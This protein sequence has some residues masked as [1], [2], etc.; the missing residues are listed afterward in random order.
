MI[1]D[2][3]FNNLLNDEEDFFNHFFELRPNPP[4]FSKLIQEDIQIYFDTSEF[5]SSLPEIPFEP[6]R[7][8]RKFYVIPSSQQLINTYLGKIE[9]IPD[10]YEDYCTPYSTS[11]KD[12]EIP[13]IWLNP[14]SIR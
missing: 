11:D 8:S 12:A 13:L 3:Y 7:P 5:L 9:E 4:L 14:K 10:V 1:E 2:D 6:R